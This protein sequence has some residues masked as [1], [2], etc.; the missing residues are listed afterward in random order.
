MREDVGDHLAL[1]RLL[2]E[3]RLAPLDPGPG[4]VVEQGAVVNREHRLVAVRLGLDHRRAGGDQRLADPLGALG[5]L[6]R[7][8][9]HPEPDLGVRPVPAVEIGPHH[10]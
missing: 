1:P 10:W 8:R 9:A 2:R 4:E 6:R 7:R 5:Q 3:P